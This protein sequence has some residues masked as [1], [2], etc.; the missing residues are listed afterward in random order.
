MIAPPATVADI[1]LPAA[2]DLVDQVLDDADQP[3]RR[4]DLVG[5]AVVDRLADHERQ[6]DRVHGREL[7]LLDVLKAE[8]A[9]LDGLPRPPRPLPIHGPPEQRP[10][11]ECGR[12]CVSLGSHRR[13]HRHP[14]GPKELDYLRRRCGDLARRCSVMVGRYNVLVRYV[15]CLEEALPVG[16][17]EQARA[18]IARGWRPSHEGLDHL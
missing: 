1:D 16:E 6:I 15:W 2:E 10:C 14:R 3:G 12:L 7:R 9:I 13:V 4:T 18:R 8:Q 17:V 5:Q 11:P